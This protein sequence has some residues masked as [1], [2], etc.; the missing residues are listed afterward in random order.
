MSNL[1]TLSRTALYE[2]VWTKPVRDIASDFGISDVALAKR[3]RA[4]KIPVPPRG[5]WARVEAGQ[6]PRRPSLPPFSVS[7]HAPRPSYVTT[8]AQADSTSAASPPTVTVTF[9]PR[10]APPPPAPDS[11]I[12]LEEAVLRAGID[13]LE[14]APLGNLIDAHPAVLRT[15]VH[16]KHLKS[17]DI[18]W[19]RGTRAGPILPVSN[20][21]DAQ[22]DRAL[23]VLGAVLRASAALG[24]HFAAPSPQEPPT[25]RG[26]GS[27]GPTPAAP[28]AVGHL[29][30][31]GEPLQL[32]I[33][34]RRRQFNHVPTPTEL[35]DKKAG[36]YVWMPRFDF[37]PSGELRLHLFDA[38]S[39]WVRKTWK[40]TKS[41]PLET[42]ASKILH[43][44][45]DR[46]LELKRDREEQRLRDLARRE[47]ERQQALVHQR[48]AAHAELIEELERQA[49]AWH[50]AQFLRRYLRAARRA[51]CDNTFNV[52]LQGKPTDFL[53]WAE[54]YVNQLDPLYAE[55]RDPD[56]AHERTFQVGADEKRLQEE[57][58]RLSGHTWER[59]SKLLART[60]GT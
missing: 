27:W 54:H 29:L 6:K 20:V 25:Y 19:P 22:I 31:D 34:E 47:H 21:S 5:Y 43:G 23:R 48:R 40:D 3:C 2:L 16:L 44:L 46:A 32:K 7:K 15:A 60:D 11:P 59:A 26:R 4:L 58:Q 52:D 9:T 8:E 14:I 41:H 33:D 38:D 10:P 42:Q 57:L 24:W 12:S 18:T 56:F 35:A 39:S 55:P 13:T 53:A 36:R 37:E 49:G 45:L 51:L 1:I 30:V 28:P 50:R 17:R